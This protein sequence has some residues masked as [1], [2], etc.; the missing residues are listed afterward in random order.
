MKTCPFFGL[1]GGCQ[2][3]FTAADYRAKKLAGVAGL[4]ITGDAIW[5]APGARRRAEF[6]FADGV[7]GFYQHRSRTIVP[8]RGCPLCCDAINSVLGQIAAMP[9]NG[10]GAVL[11]TAC[12]NG[13]DVGVTS[14]VPYFSSDFKRVAN[15]LPVIRV[16]WNAQVVAQ[17]AIPQVSFGNHTVEY[18]PNAFLQPTVVGA[19]ILRDMVV[20]AVGKSQHV[21]DLFCGLGNFTFAT[22]ADGFD[23]SGTGVRRDLF[24][25]PLTVGMLGQYDCVI[26][27]PPRAGAD[28]QCRNLAASGV[29]RVIYISCNPSTWRRD[30]NILARGGY[31]LTQLI[32]V[33]QFVGSV[34]WEL[35]SVF[36]K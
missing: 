9:W 29:A 26:M 11:V 16:T 18:P 21:A 3:D 17:T 34:H 27:D 12:D 35:F 4:P 13:I 6:A 20:Q 5:C 1:C 10:A 2:Y 15:T 30:S 36:E 22:G 24:R 23:I 33:D 7:F 32:P 31:R 25:N 8:V 14:A 28:A 19:D